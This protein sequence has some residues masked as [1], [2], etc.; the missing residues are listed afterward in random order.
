MSAIDAAR[1]V[2]T[3]E[4]LDV[5]AV[6]AFLGAHLDDDVGALEIE[7]F[8]GGHSNLTYLLR[9]GERE[10][11]LRRPP[12]GAQ[13]KSGHDMGREFRV[14]RGLAQTG[15]PAPKPIAHSDDESIL[16][17]PFYVMERVRGV[18]VRNAKPPAGHSLDSETMNALSKAC[19][20]NLIRIH[21][22]DLE[23]AGFTELGRPEGYVERQ[24][25]GWTKRYR[26]AQ[27]DEVS[28]MDV[29]AQWLSENMPP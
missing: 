22:T 18:I 7:Q 27:T 1:A 29:V 19:V 13:I 21:A 6:Q 17:A 15:A 24:V 8:P 26:N 20:D 10:F 14:L 4:E 2:R 23:Q 16:G 28:D 25:R 11:V 9:S 5:A 12:F 3:G